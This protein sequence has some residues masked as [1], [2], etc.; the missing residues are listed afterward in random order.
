MTGPEAIVI[1]VVSL[2]A[3]WFVYDAICRSPIGEN[4][5][6]LAVGRLRADRRRGLH[7]H[8]CFLRAEARSS[9]SAP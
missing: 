8:P 3:G 2:A 6:M 9:M 5:T 4:T 1:S 7:V